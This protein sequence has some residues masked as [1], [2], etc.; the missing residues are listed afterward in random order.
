MFLTLPSLSTALPGSWDTEKSPFANND[1]DRTA[2]RCTRLEQ[3]CVQ[4]LS[5]EMAVFQAA[6][7]NVC[8]TF[9]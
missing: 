6:L 7:G 1:P 5:C 2:C 4:K 3:H 8:P 9:I